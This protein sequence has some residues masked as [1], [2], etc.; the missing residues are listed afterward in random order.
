M[1]DWPVNRVDLDSLLASN[2]PLSLS[3]IDAL[4][5]S[6]KGFHPIEY[7]LFGIGGSRKAADL[8]VL[9]MKYIVSLTQSLYNTTT[10]LRE[11]WD[12]AYKNFTSQLTNAGNGSQSK[13]PFTPPFHKS[14]LRI[15]F[16]IFLNICNSIKK[17][18]CSL[19]LEF[20][21]IHSQ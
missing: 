9:E 12:P 4:P 13:T 21:T 1:D 3:D 17:N 11:S 20:I 5:T 2:N 18:N 6:L 16:L 15:D 14:S 7:I 10:A 19:I 8:T